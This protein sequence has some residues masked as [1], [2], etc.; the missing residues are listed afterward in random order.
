MHFPPEAEK[1]KMNE[2][3]ERTAGIMEK[4]LQSPR[5]TSNFV[6]GGKLTF[7]MTTMML[8]DPRPASNVARAEFEYE[9]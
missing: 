3:Y 6:F 1:R 8:P 2:A 4:S 5:E 9:R 7:R